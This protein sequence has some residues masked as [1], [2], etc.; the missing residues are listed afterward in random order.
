M[1]F[2]QANRGDYERVQGRTQQGHLWKT[3][4][5]CGYQLTGLEASRYLQ[6]RLCRAEGGVVESNAGFAWMVLVRAD[7][8]GVPS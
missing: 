7:G 3:E 2:L 6:G 4:H 8:D 5:G 1:E